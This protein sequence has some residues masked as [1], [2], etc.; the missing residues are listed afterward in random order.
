MR[1]DVV[2]ARIRFVNLF[3][4]LTLNVLLRFLKLLSQQLHLGGTLLDLLCLSGFLLGG[5][6]FASCRTTA[7]SHL[8]TLG[9]TQKKK[10]HTGLH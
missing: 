3:R 7:R 6:F 9:T 5:R 4:G 2:D 1:E 8:V 10:K